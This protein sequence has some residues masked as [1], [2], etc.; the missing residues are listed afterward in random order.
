MNPTLY[1]ARCRARMLR[2]LAAALLR[3]EGTLL[4]LDIPDAVFT[5]HFSGIAHS[6]LS[7]FPLLPLPLVERHGPQAPPLADNV[8]DTQDY[9]AFPQPFFLGDRD[10]D[11]EWLPPVESPLWGQSREVIRVRVRTPETALA[12]LRRLLHIHCN[13]TSAAAWLPGCSALLR[14]FRP[15][16]DITPGAISTASAVRAV[17]ATLGGAGYTLL[18]ARTGLPL[19]HE[20]HVAEAV[21][22]GWDI[23]AFPEEMPLPDELNAVWRCRVGKGGPE[24]REEL[25]VAREDRDA[26]AQDG[27]RCLDAR[28]LHLLPAYAAES[29]N[30]G[31]FWRWTGPHATAHGLLGLPGAGDWNIQVR[32][33]L[34]DGSAPLFPITVDGMTLTE[35]TASDYGTEAQ[36]HL[37]TRQDFC[38][39]AVHSPTFFTDKNRFLRVCVFSARVCPG[40]E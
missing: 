12:G 40:R 32:Y 21:R 3:R 34:H 15:S 24:T 35:C 5:R 2:G 23:L 29:D 38:R 1:R 8:Q 16:L 37:R 7:L 19:R 18:H 28:D 10:V 9:P 4:S 31:I 13:D 14:R 25:P 27:V 26:A 33:R 22:E 39:L 11:R 20:G 17:T 36:G 30:S 6:G